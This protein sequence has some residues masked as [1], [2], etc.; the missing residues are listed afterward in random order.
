MDNTFAKFLKPFSAY[1]FEGT[2]LKNLFLYIFSFFF[3]GG[4][5]E[6]VGHS[7]VM[8]PILFLSIEVWIRTQRAAVK[9]RHATNLATRLPDIATHL[10]ELAIHLPN[11]A[12]HPLG[13]HWLRYT[14]IIHQI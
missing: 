13:S 14:S 3:G 12:T 11:V 2:L 6:C 8:L 10:L 9:S 4:R 5:L 7:F 1:I